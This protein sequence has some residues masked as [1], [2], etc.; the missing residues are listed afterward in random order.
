[1]FEQ[2][3]LISIILPIYNVEQYLDDCLNSICTQNYQNL[4]IILVD[5][6]ATDSSPE[7]CDQ[8]GKKDPRIRVIHKENGGVCSARNAGL[9]IASG[10]YITF[11]DPDDYICPNLYR[12]ALPYLA[13]YDMIAFHHYQLGDDYKMEVKTI[14]QG[15][16]NHDDMVKINYPKMLGFSAADIKNWNR[17]RDIYENRS[18]GMVWQF[19]FKTEVIQKNHIRFKESLNFQ[20]D[21]IFT[22]ECMVC[23]NRLK[24]IEKAYYCYVQH[25]DSI[26]Y[27][28]TNEQVLEKK[29]HLLEYK[30][31]IR[32]EVAQRDKIDILDTYAGSNVLSALQIATMCAKNNWGYS[33]LKHYLELPA[34]KESI[35]LLPIEFQNIKFN[36]ALFLL[37][38]HAY[39]MVYIIVKGLYLLHINFGLSE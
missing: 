30:N 5:D 13:N 27:T 17:G 18:L 11:V 16:D 8:W 33:V 20:E 9:D 31:E 1:M 3:P 15:V 24:V 12:E 36:A 29:I 38:C 37:K 35:S 32:R 25:P 10:A 23:S 26:T 7:K 34:V 19:I 6:G 21:D 39:W 4:E 22:M 2:T 14:L 28:I